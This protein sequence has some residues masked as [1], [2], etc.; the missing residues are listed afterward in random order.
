VTGDERSEQTAGERG[1]KTAG[2]TVLRVDAIEDLDAYDSGEPPTIVQISDIH[3]YLEDGQ[4][5]LLAVG[6]VDE[7]D[8][9]VELDAENRLHWV[10]GDDYVLVVNG[11]VVDRGPAS[12]ECLELVWRLQREAPPGHVRYHLGNHEMALVLP[13]VLDWPQWYVGQQPASVSND[14]YEAILDGRAT[15]A[16]EGYEY[17]YS[18]AGS[19]EPIDPAACN[20]SLRAAVEEIR[21]APRIDRGEVQRSL[22][23][24]FPMVFG[25][26]GASGRGP[27][28]GILWLDYRHM[29]EDAPKQV[30]GHTKQ[31]K[32]TREG[33]V[34][35]GNVI[36]K[37]QG[38]IG[39]EGV[40]VETPDRIG[41]VVRKEDRSASSTFFPP[42][43]Q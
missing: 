4:S 3:G 10:G 42:L 32:P 8:P 24:R 14:F 20:E 28:A 6:E 41:V 21:S 7:F 11:D 36:R 22:V 13:A 31:M 37:N 15:V 29:P 35:C 39:G 5:A 18:H 19:P 43:D 27:G 26:G 12:D 9:I 33:N 38:T 17:T 34:V 1:G 40:I 25:M 2:E 16:F 30:V 23:D